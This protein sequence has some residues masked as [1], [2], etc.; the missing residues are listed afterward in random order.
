[1]LAIAGDVADTDHAV[2]VIERTVERFGKLDILVNNAGISMRGS[3]EELTQEVCRRV[4]DT[5]TAGAVAMSKAAV[6]HIVETGG[7]LVFISSIAGL[8]G[9]PGASLY[10]ASKAAL[11]G[12]AESLRLELSGQGVHAGV[13]HLGF[14]EHDPE[15]RILAADG[16]EVLPDRP[17][18]HTQLH[19]AL[20]ILDMM[21]KRRRAVVLTAAGKLG[22]VAYRLSPGLVERA[23]LTAQSARWGVFK[24]FS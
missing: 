6:S 17:E 19:A 18:H 16:S 21:E 13:V 20:E 12:F 11:T 10:C 15:K 7:H 9:L 8:F 24:Q 5:N 4:L 14:T 1:V 22:K 2:E 23:I 3:F